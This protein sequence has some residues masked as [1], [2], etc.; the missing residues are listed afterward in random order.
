MNS[1]SWLCGG[2]NAYGCSVIEWKDRVLPSY[3]IRGA[4]SSHPHSS[5]CST[6]RHAVLSIGGTQ[7]CRGCVGAAP[8]SVEIAAANDTLTMV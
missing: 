5:S 3:A 1:Y 2:D 8:W 7:L 6:H 4:A